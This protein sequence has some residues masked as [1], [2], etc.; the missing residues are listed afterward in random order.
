M[1]EH[2]PEHQPEARAEPD[3]IHDDTDRA[4]AYHRVA[5]VLKCKWTLAVLES[6]DAGEQRPSDILRRLP[7]LTSKVLSDRLRKLED[8]GL[9]SR[10]PYAEVPPRV[11]YALTTQGRDLARIARSVFEYV[12]RYLTSRAPR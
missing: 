7:G 11:E 5:D 10:T 9:I 6:L 4:E 12:E 2:Q 3:S 8:F 1:P